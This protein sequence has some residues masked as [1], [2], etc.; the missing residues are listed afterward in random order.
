MSTSSG[1]DEPNAATNISA[2][3]FDGIDVSASSSRLIVSS[4]ARPD[5]VAS[6]PSVVP[7]SAASST[8]ASASSTVSRV[9]YRMRLSMSRPRKPEPNGSFAPNGAN[10]S[11]VTIAPTSC[12]AS[13]G[14]NTAMNSIRPTIDRPTRPPVVSL[15]RAPRRLRGWSGDGAAGG[16]APPHGA[17][18]SPDGGSALLR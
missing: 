16:V 1:S 5:T 18:G 10:T 6:S 11:G 17:R 3:I 15:M 2:N 12:G 13:S 14:A 4:T 8:A 9:P 7:V